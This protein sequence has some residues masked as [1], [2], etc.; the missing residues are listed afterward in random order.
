LSAQSV[1]DEE[2]LN[3]TLKLLCKT[4]RSITLYA[5][6]QQER[7]MLRSDV[8]AASIKWSKTSVRDWV[9][10]LLILTAVNILS[11]SSAT[12]L[13]KMCP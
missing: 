10:T 2:A 7:Y 13:I 3:F 1:T 6:Q 11:T 12:L 9:K 8:L 4:L 5:D